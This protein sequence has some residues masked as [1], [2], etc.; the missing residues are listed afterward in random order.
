M[1]TEKQQGIDINIPGHCPKCGSS[2]WTGALP[3]DVRCGN[4]G[5]LFLLHLP[6]RRHIPGR[7]YNDQVCRGCGR[8][9]NSQAEFLS[10]YSG[11]CAECVRNRNRQTANTVTPATVTV[12]E[13]CPT[14]VQLPPELGVMG[15]GVCRLPLGHFGL[16]NVLR[17]RLTA[18]DR[19]V[20]KHQ[21]QTAYTTIH[22]SQM[23]QCLVCQCAEAHPVHNPIQFQQG[24]PQNDPNTQ[25]TAGAMGPEPDDQD[26]LNQEV[27]GLR[28][29]LQ[30]ALN[31]KATHPWWCRWDAAGRCEC[32]L[33]TLVTLS[34]KLQ[35]QG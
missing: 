27:S 1:G 13:P 33:T 23:N 8:M 22:G 12:L 28:E 5:Y 2:R 20:G 7:D 14:D 19:M 25:N 15:V 4:C 18:S 11:L 9:G 21:F 10:P 35:G 34:R 24:F 31:L 29:L 6:T 26:R 30:A 16:H 17:D 3:A 32:G